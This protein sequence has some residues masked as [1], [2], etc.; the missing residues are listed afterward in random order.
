M[1]QIP[2]QSEGEEKLLESESHRK[3]EDVELVLRFFTYPHIERNILI[4]NLR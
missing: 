3:M 2:L 4:L 1:W